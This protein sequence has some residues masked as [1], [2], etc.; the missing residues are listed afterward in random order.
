MVESASGKKMLNPSYLHMPLPGSIY[1]LAKLQNWKWAHL[2][3]NRGGKEGPV[4]DEEVKHSS[5]LPINHPL[6]AYLHFSLENIGLQWSRSEI[7]QVEMETACKRS[8]K[9]LRDVCEHGLT[10]WHPLQPQSVDCF[11]RVTIQQASLTLT[12]MWPEHAFTLS[13]R[14]NF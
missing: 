14:Q 8:P 1:Y 10:L 4:E 9:V 6:Q 12:L 5:L 11:Q 3:E 2:E 13:E 7:Y